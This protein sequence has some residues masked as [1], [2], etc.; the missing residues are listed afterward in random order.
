MGT[1]GIIYDTTVV[2]EEDIGWDILWDEDYSGRILMFDNPRDAFA[3][4]EN[5]LEYL[6]NTENSEE[7]EKAAEKL[8]EQ[9]KLFRR[10]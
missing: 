6:L 7:L 5:M 1:V 3:I 9:K 10:M 8:K 4:A 2:D